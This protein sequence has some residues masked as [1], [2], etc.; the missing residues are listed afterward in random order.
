ML[1]LHRDFTGVR[2]NLNAM[3]NSS[4]FYREENIYNSLQL[5]KVNEPI[6]YI[7]VQCGNISF[8]KS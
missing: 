4:A 2:G 5:S 8:L 1:Y 6:D 3:K 7:T